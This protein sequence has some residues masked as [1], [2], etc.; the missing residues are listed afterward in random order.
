MS[1]AIG[2]PDTTEHAPYYGKYVELVPE[3]DIV[4]TLRTQF[5]E[6]LEMFRGISEEKAAT[7][8]APDKWSIKEVLGHVIDGERVFSYR[9]L[10][11]ARGD[12][13]EIPGFEQDDY[14][15]TG[16]FD[17]RTLADL[18]NEYESVRRG[19][20]TLLGSFDSDAWARRGVANTWEVS[21][22]ALGFIIAGHERHH[23][24]V[25]KERYL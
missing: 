15:R 17:R 8:Y 5:Q 13:T 10:T 18:V 3:G 19:T 24:K 1:A 12:A 22:R 20:L 4:E 11:F 2:R 25:L 7:R 6:S 16:Q 21:V 23:V 14:V 9:A